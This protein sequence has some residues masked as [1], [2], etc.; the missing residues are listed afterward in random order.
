MKTPHFEKPAKLL[1]QGGTVVDP[2]Q[3]L[4]QKADILIEH[5]RITAVGS[6]L[7]VEDARVV[8]CRGLIISP[9]WLDMHVHF[10]EPGR[11]DE[12][13][14]R[15]GCHAAAA[16]GF[17]GACP[18]PNTEP[19]ADQRGIIEYMIAEAADTPVEVFPIAAATKNRAG[20]ELS[21]M[22]D[23]LE[24]GAVAFSDDGVSIATAEMA[25]RAM[26]YASMFDVPIIE[27]CEEP[28][29]TEKG[30]MHEGAVSTRL[31]IPGMP[32]VAEDIIVARD[33]L[34]AEFTGARLHI[35]H[36]STA[37][38]I[39]LVRQ[40]KAKGIRVTCEVT[41]H[42]FTLTDEAVASYDANYKMNPPLRSAQDV[43]AVIEGLRD[44][45]ID[46]IATDHAPHSPEE[47]D[48]EFTLAPF[49]IIGL[50][51]AM[52][53]IMTRLVKP[54]HLSLTEALRK[55]TGN[56]RRILKL[57]V[58]RIEP[59]Q[60]ANLTLFHPDQEW[61][62]DDKAFY[63]RSRNSPFIGWK[64]QGKIHGIFNRGMLWLNPGERSEP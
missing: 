60:P 11:E 33:I 63:S 2:E 57:T 45:T 17:T 51:T 42:H 53:L 3:A 12:E 47:K 15:T 10:R 13:T 22:A 30:A 46:V 6:H 25:R 26:E 37:R 59:N 18:M 41:P 9:G 16:G 4:E 14:V 52:G 24:G 31:G 50:E 28:S 1:L 32:G 44:G 40:A 54:G 29:L 61:V 34:L 39:E 48:V 62:V 58:P 56:P 20:R 43:E 7:H 38:S 64:L 55:I 35:A 36:I 49:G 23:L 21:E 8:D 5:G 27:H 19:A